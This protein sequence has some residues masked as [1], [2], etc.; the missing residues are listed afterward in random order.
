MADL[1]ELQAA[2]P[3][4]IIGSD[5]TGNETNAV[6]ATPTG[7]LTVSDGLSA[8]GLVGNLN[9]V[10]ANTAYEAKVSTSRLTNRKILTIVAFDADM[11][12][13]MSNTVTTSTGF[14][15]YKGQSVSFS[16]DANSPTFQVW[17]VCSGANKNARIME[18]P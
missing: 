5:L 12:F 10:T 11:F 13:G 7:D 2:L 17:L 18:T 8:G 14:P 3:S 9:L 15:L 16:I 4:K 6:N 1:T